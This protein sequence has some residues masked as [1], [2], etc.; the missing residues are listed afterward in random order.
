MRISL[1]TTLQ[2]TRMHQIVSWSLIIGLFI[3]RI[4]LLGFGEWLFPTPWVDN[5]YQVGTYLL[6][7]VFLWWECKNLPDFHV[8]ALALWI[9]VLFEPAMTLIWRIWNVHSPLAFPNTSAKL[10]WLIASGLAI[11][12]WPGRKSLPRFKW[13][14]LGWFGIGTLVGIG[15]A[16]LL[17]V[18]TSFQVVKGLSISTI[19]STEKGV[20]L[21][22]FI[23]VIGYAGV[24]EEP[25]FRGFLWGMLRKAGWKE[26]WIWVFQAALFV[27]GHIY[28]LTK[29]P[30][31]FFVIVPVAALILGLLV[32]KARTISATMAAHGAIDTLGYMMGT[33][34]A[35][36]LK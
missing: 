31:S 3:L 29:F 5:V 28:Y 14:S 21:P 16:I 18:P 15:T 13:K 12:L 26:L 10:I 34:A 9:I 7:A 2:N 36:Y 23:E 33:L 1:E 8:D 25:L 6:T 11:A 20:L 27:L 4:L 24:A 17:A 19:W 22:N 32:W 30:I 35:Y